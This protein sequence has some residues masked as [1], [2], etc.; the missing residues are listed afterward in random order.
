MH[1]YHSIREKLLHKLR[2]PGRALDLKTEDLI[3]SDQTLLFISQSLSRISMCKLHWYYT[4]FSVLYLNYNALSQSESS[5][6]FVYII[7]S[8]IKLNE[9]HRE[10]DLES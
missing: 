6:F 10:F 2:H 8:E 1:A 7:M 5:N 3:V 9:R 4:F